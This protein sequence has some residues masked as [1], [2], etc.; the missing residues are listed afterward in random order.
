MS[1][2]STFG[3]GDAVLTTVPVQAIQEFGVEFDRQRLKYVRSSKSSIGARHT[4][5]VVQA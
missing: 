2:V 1:S 3:N 4:E 5:S